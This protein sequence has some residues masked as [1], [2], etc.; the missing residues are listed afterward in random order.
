M[1]IIRKII[2]MVVLT[3]GLWGGVALSAPAYADDAMYIGV[4]PMRESVVLNPGDKY[5]GSFF[6]NNPGYSEVDTPYRVEVKPFYVDEEYTPIFTNENDSGLIADWITIVSGGSGLLK[7]NDVEVVEFEINV[8][9]DAPAGSQYAAIGVAVDLPQNSLEGGINIGEGMVVNHVVL[10]EITG[11]TVIAG[12]ILDVGVQS[13]MLDGAI[14]AYSTVENTGNIHG[15][16]SYTVKVY[17]LFSDEVLYSNEDIIET[18]YVLP[19]RKYYNESYW[20]ETPSIGIF[21]VYYKV[22]FQGI[23]TEVTRMVIVCPWWLLFIIALALAI[24]VIRII[25]LARLRKV[26]KAVF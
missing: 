18:H 9:E 24:L 4:S 6:V 21:N 13:F 1:N 5:K 20:S 16:A 22:E 23:V 8:P 11:S 19:G 10:A 14:T 17:P 15:L 2:V 26:N 7:P 12:D 3:A 25:T